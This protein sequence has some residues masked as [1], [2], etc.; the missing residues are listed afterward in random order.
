MTSQNRRLTLMAMFSCI[1][2][3]KAARCLIF[4]IWFTLRRLPCGMIWDRCKIFDFSYIFFLYPYWEVIQLADISSLFKK[5]IDKIN[6]PNYYLI[7]IFPGKKR[8]SKTTNKVC[9][10]H[11]WGLYVN[12]YL[13][14]VW[15][16]FY[17]WQSNHIFLFYITFLKRKKRGSLF[18]LWLHGSIYN[19]IWTQLNYVYL[20]TCVY[21]FRYRIT[22]HF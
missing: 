22:N 7:K 13:H 21:W 6:W 10:A 15:F 16:K 11:C 20:S 4:F 5:F 12:G 14:V 2:V 3:I 1:T 8:K 9:F 18:L 17:H 19:I